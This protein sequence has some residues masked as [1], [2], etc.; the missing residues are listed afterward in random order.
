MALPEC[1]GAQPQ[2]RQPQRRALTRR[3]RRRAATRHSLGGSLRGPTQT[4]SQIRNRSSALPPAGLRGVPPGRLRARRRPRRVGLSNPHWRRRLS[5]AGV[6]RRL[7]PVR[8]GVRPPAFHSGR[9]RVPLGAAA[10]HFV[11]A[12]RDRGGDEHRGGVHV[13]QQDGEETPQ[14]ACSPSRRLVC[15]AG[16]CSSVWRL[17]VASPRPPACG[18]AYLRAGWGGEASEG[19]AGNARCRHEVRESYLCAVF[20]LSSPAPRR[21]LRLIRA[22]SSSCNRLNASCLSLLR[23]LQAHEGSVHERL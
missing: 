10:L 22:L 23:S 16:D 6:R 12:A 4:Y 5:P 3:R 8:L 20:V 21:S 17:P 2:P 18:C 19:R 11:G 14:Q 7:R 9:R 13:P 15:C 1:A